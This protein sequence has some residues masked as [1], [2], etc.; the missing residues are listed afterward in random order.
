[1][2]CIDEQITLALIQKI[3]SI[4]IANGY[5]YD[6]GFRVERVRAS[7]VDVAPYPLTLIIEN[8]P[9]PDSD[10]TRLRSDKLNYALLFLDGKSDED[11]DDPPI[12]QR[13]SNCHADLI[14]CLAEDQE[15]DGL[16]E[17]ISVIDHD[18]TDT[19][20]GWGFL[21]FI[22]ISRIIDSENPYEK[23]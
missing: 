6:I 13:L 23:P 1:M 14:K 16:C 5:Q 17:G 11:P 12:F 9:D 15:L 4:T 7:G 8:L 21:A 18:I 2:N 22:E 20:L 3:Q 10:Y 19:E